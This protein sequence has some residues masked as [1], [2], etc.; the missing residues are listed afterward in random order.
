MHS[1]IAAGR[2]RRAVGWIMLWVTALSSAACNVRGQD[3]APNHPSARKIGQFDVAGSISRDGRYLTYAKT[4]E[5]DELFVRELI[6]GEDRR[7]TGRPGEVGEYGAP[8]SPTGDVVVYSWLVQLQGLREIRVVRL[9]GSGLRVL[10][11][12]DV[13]VLANPEDWSPDGKEILLTLSN[14]RTRTKGLALLSTTT[15]SL[16]HVDLPVG[17]VR[18][19]VMGGES[20]GRFSPNGQW[21]AFQ[22]PA[23]LASAAGDIFVV[24]VD[25]SLGAPVVTHPANDRLLGWTPDGGRILFASDRAGTWDLWAQQIRDGRANGPADIIRRGI[26]QVVRSAGVTKDGSLH[27]VLKGWQNDVY[28]ATIGTSGKIE[29]TTKVAANVAWDSTVQWSPDGRFLVYARGNGNQEDPFVMVVHDSETAVERWHP[30]QVTRFGGHFFT[31]NWAPDGRAVLSQGRHVGF[32]GSKPDSQ[33]LYRIDIETGEATPLVQTSDLCPPDCVE[34][35]A[36]SPTGAVLFVRWANPPGTPRRVVAR[37]LQSGTERELYRSVRGEEIH[38]LA[39]SPDGQRLAVAWWDRSGERAGVKVM[40]SSGQEVRD[41]LSLPLLADYWLPLFAM[42]WTPDSRHL[43]YAPTRRGEK[44][45]ELKRVSIDGGPPEDLGLS[46]EGV[47]PYGL[48]VHPDGRRIVF[49]AGSPLRQEVW[50]L[51][52]VAEA[53][54]NAR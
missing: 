37:D 46:M 18:Q 33:G 13:D 21:I 32:R 10:Y 31:P 53:T 52:K 7:L 9:D 29:R 54:G 17:S 50:V 47:W 49:T 20:S 12:A 1:K 34:W 3:S 48:S 19:P 2:L 11:R 22:S 15:G 6:T 14:R 39:V 25:G 4:G 36:W 35:P 24:S 28:V 51:P 30:L 44:R 42:A 40:G 43:I 26:G 38:H 5:Y 16:R 8:I 41:V 23:S 45:V 27:Y